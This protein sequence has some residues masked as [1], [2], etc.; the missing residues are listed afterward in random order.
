MEYLNKQYLLD[1]RPTGMPEDDCWKLN[2]ELITSLKKN[3]IIMEIST[4][5][6]F[7]WIPPLETLSGHLPSRLA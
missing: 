6:H 3:E 2:D 7:L 1:K 5:E 4:L